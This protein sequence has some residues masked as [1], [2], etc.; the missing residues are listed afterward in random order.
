MHNTPTLRYQLR[1]EANSLQ[2]CNAPRCQLPRYGLEVHCRRHGDIARRYGHPTARPLKR[3]AIAPYVVATRALW[4]KN[5]E[6]EGLKHA[7]VWMVDL[8]ARGA[9][10]CTGFFGAYE[11]QRLAEAG[12]TGRTILEEVVGCALYLQAR[13]DELPSDEARSF[14]LARAACA[15]APQRVKVS[16]HSG[17]AKAYRGKA[18]RSSLRHLGRDFRVNLAGLIAITQQGVEEMTR[19]ANRSVQEVAAALNASFVT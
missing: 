1:R 12:I 5:P 9:S 19:K 13:P 2:T 17:K 4:A 14:A 10:N 15:L 16:Y 3:S 7:T 8:V 6:H 11:L 18:S